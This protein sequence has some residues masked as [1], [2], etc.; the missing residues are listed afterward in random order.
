MQ[1]YRQREPEDHDHRQCAANDR[2]PSALAFTVQQGTTNIP[3]DQPIAIASSGAALTYTATASTN[4][5]GSWLSVKS[6]ASGSTPANATIG[7]VNYSSLAPGPYTG[8]ISISSQAANSPVSVPV[9]LTVLAAVPLT[10]SR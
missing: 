1:E 2:E 10:V 7:V 4:G 9:T 5:G 8:S 3:A 6:Q